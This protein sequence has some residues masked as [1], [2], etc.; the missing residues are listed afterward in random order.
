MP[1]VNESTPRTEITIAGET[2][3]VAQ[4]YAE[5][6]VLTANEASALN[7][8]FAENIRNNMAAKVKEFKESTTWDHDVVQGRVDD[9]V[10][11]YEFGVRTGGGRTGDPVRAE[12]MNIAR[13]LVRREIQRQGKKLADYTAARI[14]E[15]AKSILDRGDS[16]SHTILAT[17]KARVEA[18]SG[19]DIKLDSLDAG[20]SEAKPKA[21]SK[22]EA[23]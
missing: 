12:A 14:S 20:N 19:L 23:A 8:T 5:G 6:H 13:D 2:F 7:Q 21:K 15:L 17:A 22:A 9:Y 18:A 4:P 11:E 16:N 1:D 3:S 10:D